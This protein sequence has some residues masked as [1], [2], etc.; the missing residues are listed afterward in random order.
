MSN[1]D[2]GKNNQGIIAN[3]VVSD[4]VAV[5]YRSKAKQIVTVSSEDKKV[6]KDSIAKIQES[7]N[8]LG[9]AKEAAAVVQSDVNK[10]KDKIENDPGDKD[11]IGNLVQQFSE[12]LKMVGVIVKDTATLIE[13]LKKIAGVLGLGISFF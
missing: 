4:V 2:P 11:S 8:E 7:V 10:L 6:I 3:S 5:G 9:L 12:K 13:P 1:K